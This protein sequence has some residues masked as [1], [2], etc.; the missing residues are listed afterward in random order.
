M[1]HADRDALDRPRS[2]ATEQTRPCSGEQARRAGQIAAI[3]AG[4]S[5]TRDFARRFF[6]AMAN[7]SQW[8]FCLDTAQQWARDG[9]AHFPR[10]PALLLALGATLEEKATLAALPPRLEECCSG[11]P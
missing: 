1:L 3:L 4:R 6:L 8:D 2:A 5:D 9:L 10:D 7:R 11:T